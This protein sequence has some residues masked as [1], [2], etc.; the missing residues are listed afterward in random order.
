M[1]KHSMTMLCTALCAAATVVS[2]SGC[3][4]VNQ[5]LGRNEPKATPVVVKSAEEKKAFN[6]HFSGYLV[7]YTDMEEVQAATGGTSLRWVSPQLK[8]GQYN[9]IMID[10]I[11]LYP[12]PPLLS[13]A[14]KGKMLEALRY[15]TEQAKKEIGKDLKIV[16][17]PGP[18]VLRLDAAITGVKPIEHKTEAANK[19]APKTRA[20]ENTTVAMIFTDISPVAAANSRGY[21]VYL[22]AKLRDSQTNALVTK[23]VRSG[24]GPVV[25]DSKKKVTVDEMKPVLDGWVRDAGVFIR[26]H[27]R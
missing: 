11:G 26:E 19:A 10:P 16:D 15:I 24:I 2:L 3:A 6:S 18:G 7:D 9:A 22:E 8:K 21:V 12:R 27:I 20:T 13:R 5:W 17:K 14:S 1:K 4:T 25:S 23:S